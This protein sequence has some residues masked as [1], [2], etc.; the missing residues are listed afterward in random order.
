VLAEVPPR[1]PFRLGGVVI[2]V[3]GAWIRVGGR[4][5][6]PLATRTLTVPG[7]VELPEIGRALEARLLPATGYAVPRTVDRAAFDAV[8]MPR[9]LTVRARRRGERFHAF[10]GG[11]RR[12]KSFLID[13]KVPRWDR[14]RIPLVEAGGELLW[15]AG[16]RRAAAAPV[17][18]ATREIL[19][20]R[21]GPPVE[22]DDRMRPLTS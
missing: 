11:E 21:L 17:T 20:L 5:P 15:L 22:P 9:R 19:E 6:V 13:A 7:R 2:D 4:P 12:L 16:L 3:S 1:R 18:D 14:A 8:S 10:G